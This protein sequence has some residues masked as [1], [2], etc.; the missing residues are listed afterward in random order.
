[1]AKSPFTDDPE[2]KEWVDAAKEAV[3]EKDGY[4]DLIDGEGHQYVD[5]V[6]EGGGMLG[7]ALLG[8]TH[9][10]EECGIRFWAIG[11]T[12]AG[13][14][15]ATMLAA[16]SD[17]NQAKSAELASV[18]ADADVRSF[19][20]GDDD[21]QDFVEV[22]LKEDRWFG[23]A[24]K[25]AQ[26][27]DTLRES[28]GLN[29]G[30]E[31][32]QWLREL[33]DKRKIN[34]TKALLER[35]EFVPD[36]TTIRPQ[37]GAQPTAAKP[38]NTPR[39]AVV[40]AEIGTETRVHFPEMAE[41]F[42]RRPDQVHPARYVRASMSIPVFFFPFEVSPLPGGARREKRWKQELLWEGEIPKRAVF[43]DG[44]IMSNFPI[45]LFHAHGEV[46]SHPTFGVKLGNNPTEPASI[47]GPI[48]LM[49][50]SFNSAR[51]TLDNNFIRNNPDYELL[52]SCIPTKG[53]NWLDFGMTL[54][55]QV[56]LFRV[57]AKTACHFLQQFSWTDYKSI[58]NDLAS[59]VKTARRVKGSA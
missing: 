42:W 54:E 47:D 17:K 45:D 25:F 23:K 24:W 32:E 40:S 3:A 1:M 49:L 34:T 28:K 26:V 43:V 44:G 18:L 15:V 58:R 59:A 19:V 37:A 22:M 35:L 2:V 33:L 7:I 11:G 6:M 57:G 30:D 5:L 8:Y 14:I 36:G 55:D 20:D 4:S 48:D 56:R 50:A 53:F 51:H 52:V 39:L 10:L 13:S 12:S 29:P 16:W 31:F 46:P 21:V 27:I 9:V 41:L 38:T